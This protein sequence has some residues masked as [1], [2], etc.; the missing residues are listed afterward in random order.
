MVINLAVHSPAAN[1]TIMSSTPSRPKLPPSKVSPPNGVEKAAVLLKCLA[2]QS[3]DKVLDM[4]GPEKSQRL[5]EALTDIANRP[6]QA[7]LTELVLQ[8]FRELQKEVRDANRVA[9]V[10]AE[11]LV[12]AEEP[13]ENTPVEGFV[14]DTTRREVTSEAHDAEPLETERATDP[15]VDPLQELL[16]APPGVLAAAIKIE[17]PRISALV[18]KQLPTDISGKVL[19][20][21]ESEQR[22]QVI[23]QLA[24]KSQVHPDVA[25]GVLRTIAA[26]S[27]TIDPEAA[28]Q[29]DTR[30]KTMVGILQSIE[31]EE[32]IKLMD[33]LAEHDQELA[34]RI[35]DSLYDF[36]DLMR[37]EDR[38]VQKLL[39]QLEQKVVALALKSASDEMKQK[40]FRNLSERVQKMLGE[41]MELLGVVPASRAEPARK[42]IAN[43]IRMQD[44]EG[45]LVWME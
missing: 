7:E 28:V 36:S 39:S 21:L 30:F 16:N 4:V 26:V 18:L 9:A 3:L 6:D 23:V 25:K 37:I 22:R 33:V 31:R 34:A 19:E 15:A 41:E 11:N 1:G 17:P 14:A 38:S 12:R 32:R 2:P 8:E 45:A 43:V 44:K 40:V 5:R 24:S 29:E 13:I 10:I 27:R 42:E 20:Q 35:D